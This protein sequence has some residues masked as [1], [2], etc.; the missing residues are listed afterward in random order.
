MDASLECCHVHC[1]G[2]CAGPDAEF[3]IVGLERETS[4][5]KIPRDI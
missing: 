2:A 3:A 4:L 1:L 5:A